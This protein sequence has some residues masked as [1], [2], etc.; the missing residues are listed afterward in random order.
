MD[1][2]S[3]LKALQLQAYELQLQELKQQLIE[4]TKQMA[5]AYFERIE[6]WAR[7]TFARYMEQSKWTNEQWREKYPRN[8]YFKG[9]VYVVLSIEGNREMAETQKAIQLGESN[10]L[11]AQLK[12]AHDHYF[13]CIEKLLARIQEKG[14]KLGQITIQTATIS[15]NLNTT[16]TD[17]EQ[18]ITAQTIFANGEI[19][20]PHYR[21]LVK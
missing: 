18:T 21:Y 14:L 3:K 17:G 4:G 5:D 13:A 9:N 1:K 15:R 8:A 6:K 10:Y 12:M 19:V 11:Q 20:R 16:I 7:V 2:V